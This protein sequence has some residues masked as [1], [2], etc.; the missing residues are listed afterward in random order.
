M[1]V[2]LS[3]SMYLYDISG[4]RTVTIIGNASLSS[5]Y[6]QAVGCVIGRRRDDNVRGT[7]FYI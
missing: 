7:D 4:M 6:P 1:A 3:L 5:S 2:A